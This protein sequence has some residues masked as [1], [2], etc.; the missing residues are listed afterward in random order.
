MKAFTAIVIVLIAM[1]SC[2]TKEPSS[3]LNRSVASPEEV[4]TVPNQSMPVVP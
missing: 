4:I 2:A 1:S 3:D